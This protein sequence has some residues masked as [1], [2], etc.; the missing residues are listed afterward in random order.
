LLDRHLAR[1]SASAHEL[2]F[3]CDRHALRNAIQVLCFEAETE[4]KLRLVLARSGAYSLE[5]ADMPPALAEPVPCVV[6]PLPVDAGDWRLRH[7][8]SDRSF[9]EAGLRAAKGAGAGEALFIRDD[10][11][12]T[13]GCFTNIFIARDGLWL[14]PPAPLGLLPGTLRAAMLYDGQAREAE[15][16]LDDLAEGFAIGNALRGLMPAILSPCC[17]I[18]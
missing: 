5:I 4:S 8:T 1:L 13:E 10:G 12:L 3:A 18:D 9:Y 15:L 17:R 14:T 2:G 11:L 7:K 16:R 6:L